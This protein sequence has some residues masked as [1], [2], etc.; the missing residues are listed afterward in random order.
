VSKEGYFGSV[1]GLLAI[2]VGV[3]QAMY[4]IIPPIVGWPIVATLGFGAVV[5]LIKGASTKQDKPAIT[6]DIPAIA[7]HPKTHLSWRD[8]VALNNIEAKMEE[9]HGHNDRRAMEAD[10]LRGVSASDL[11]RMNCTICFKP[12]DL[13][14][15]DVL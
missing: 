7:L 12:R 6:H 9:L 4:P 10:M 11:I 3:L 8:R 5:L 1:L 14:D 13:K 2:I 15:E